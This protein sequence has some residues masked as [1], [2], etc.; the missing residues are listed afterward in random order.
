MKIGLLIAVSRELEAFLNSGATTL[1]IPSGCESIGA[2]AFKNS[3]LRTVTVPASVT[4]IAEDAFAGCGKII[5]ITTST[6]ALEYAAEKGH[7]A[8]N[9]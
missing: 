1:E 8:V 6:A 4:Q 2:G 9:P 7:F 3:K 5:F